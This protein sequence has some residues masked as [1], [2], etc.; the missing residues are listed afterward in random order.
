MCL[1]FIE[2]LRRCS[3]VFISDIMDSALVLSF[4]IVML[5]LYKLI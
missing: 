4:I 2:K 5:F 1:G 3:N